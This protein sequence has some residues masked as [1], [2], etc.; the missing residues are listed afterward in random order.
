MIPK[1]LQ[2]KNFLSYG[3]EAQTVD[4]ST[5]NL[6]CLCGKNGHGKSALLDAI[7]WSVWGHA[8]KTSGTSKADEGLVHLGQKHMLVVFDFICN[9]EHYRIR[10][11]F[12]KTK[13]KPFSALDFGIV[14]DDDSFSTLTDKTIK[15]T[16]TKIEKTIGVTY[17]SFVNSAFLRQ[18]QANEFS[19]KS[20]KERKEILATILQLQQFEDI[21]KVALEKNKALCKQQTQKQSIE[22]RIN[23]EIEFLQKNMDERAIVTK[24]LKALEIKDAE[25]N[26]IIQATEKNQLQL[27]TK[28]EKKN[29]IEAEITQYQKQEQDLKKLI[30]EELQKYNK[31]QEEQKHISNP[32]AI[33]KKHAQLKAAIK[34]HQEK[35]NKRLELKEQYLKLQEDKHLLDTDLQQTT[36]QLLQKHEIDCKLLLEQA[37]HQKKRL[38]E[39]EKKYESLQKT[40]L[41]TKQEIDKNHTILKEQKNHSIK[42]QSYEKDFENNK[43]AYQKM[44]TEGTILQQKLAEF[45]HKKTLTSDNQNP[46]CPLCEQNLSGSRK[47]FLEK[48]IDSE[49]IVTSHQVETIKEKALKL[50]SQLIDD[51]KTLQQYKQ[52]DQENIKLSMK[53]EE[54]EKQFDQQTKQSVVEKNQITDIKTTI[55]SLEKKYATAFENQE[56]VKNNALK[57]FQNQTNYKTLLK[58]I[59]ALKQTAQKLAYDKHL[60]AS[61]QNEME[62]IEKDLTSYQSLQ[63]EIAQQ[64]ERKQRIDAQSKK[65]KDID[66]IIKKLGLKLKPFDDINAQLDLKKIEL[67]KHKQEFNALL[68]QK[69]SL[70]HKKGAF[71]QQHEKLLTLRKELISIEKELKSVEMEIFDFT[72]IIKALG[73]DGLQALL[74]EE[75]LPEIE[76]E[77]NIILAQLTDNQTQIFIES[78]R[79][80]KKG[81]SKETLDIKISDATGLRS[82]EMFSGGEAFRIDFAL[83][84]AIS[85]LLA[86]RSGTSLQTL[87]I[88]EGFGSQDED[89]LQLIMD[90]IHKIQDNFAKVIIVSHL[91]HLKEQFP[92]QFHITKK[93]S[94]SVI[95]VIEQ[96]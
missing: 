30:A 69:T 78:L 31:V 90:S 71:D 86:R 4:F 55:K 53:T 28:K 15:T 89:G 24:S 10:R 29:L 67:T 40:S 14:T 73:K 82:Y 44:V 12:I 46:C 27:Q 25:I 95:K 80:L 51:H 57:N 19:K 68:S 74:I 26:K 91:P 42:L 11:E 61:T 64:A 92:V 37:D 65:I 21:K 63:S 23:E 18:G 76:Q 83:R 45:D 22:T 9:G 59:D 49:K 60:H 43:I 70:L 87:I 3:P 54:L 72:E 34:V 50:K 84:I 58:K 32:E 7:T 85:K 48:K 36:T 35:Y 13:S 56:N 16:Q 6:I 38:I 96:G 81:G 79:D 75:A 77:A 2:I 33:K 94:G 66:T 93:A 52:N 1:K 5:Y 20:P 62:A 39:E 41:D 8:R 17:D 47:K 88:D